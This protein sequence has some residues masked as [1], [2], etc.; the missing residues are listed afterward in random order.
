MN[1]LFETERLIVRHYTKDDSDDFFLLNGDEEI[2]RYIRPAKSREECDEFLL[3]I[4]NRY[5]EKP[6]EGRWAAADKH[7]HEFIG[8]L[9]FIPIPDPDKSDSDLMQLGYSLLK[10]NWGQ[11]YATEL[12]LAGIDYVFTKTSLTEIFAVTEKANTASQK[13]LVKSGFTYEIAYTEGEKELFRYRLLKN[14]YRHK[15]RD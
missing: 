2:M 1:I 8:S 9:A 12:T 7:T 6:L 11:G 4:I 10:Q 3:Q 13:V 5:D 15:Q 14:D